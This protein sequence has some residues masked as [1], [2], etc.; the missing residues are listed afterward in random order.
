[1]ATS[2]KIDDAS[3]PAKKRF[4]NIIPKIMVTMGDY[5][6]CNISI[7]P[8]AI[9]MRFILNLKFFLPKKKFLPYKLHNNN[10]ILTNTIKYLYNLNN[11]SSFIL[12]LVSNC[13]L[14]AGFLI[15]FMAVN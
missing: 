13:F 9:V 8:R 11:L 3:L 12:E 10:D 4:N 7:Q 2:I 15:F 1:L 14:I 6:Y 5:N